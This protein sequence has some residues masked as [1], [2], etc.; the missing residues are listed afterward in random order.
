MGDDGV[1]YWGYEDSEGNEDFILDDD[2][3]RIPVTGT[4]PQ[5]RINPQTGNWEISTDGGIEWTDTGMPSQGTGD[6]LFEAVDQDEDYVYI[7]LRGGETIV[8]PKAKELL[9]DFGTDEEILY[10]TPGETKTL[11]YTMSGASDYSI[12]KPDGWRVMIEGSALIITAPAADNAFAES[13]GNINIILVA[14][15]GQ[16]LIAKLDVAVKAQ[17]EL[18]APQIGDFFYSDGTWSSEYDASKTALGIVFQTDPARIGSAETE[19]GFN[20]GLVMALKIA[21]EYIGW[22]DIK[23][24]IPELENT[25]LDAFYSDLSGLHNCTTV[26]NK[27]NYDASDYKA[28]G[29]VAAWNEEGSQYKAPA[30]TSGWFIPSSGQMYDMF[31]NL[32]GLGDMDEADNSGH[33]YFWEGNSYK[34]FAGKLNAWMDEIPDGQ[35]DLF[36]ADGSS[37]HLWTSSETYDSNARAWAIYAVG[38]VECESCQKTWGADMSVRAI[39][40]F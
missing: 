7:T 38:T 22:S 17:Q 20:H 32:A 24:D 10:F 35:K 30:N 5:V 26:W 4:A 23:E 33:N 3:N 34:D 36:M 2:G 13:E 12:A 1:Y 15:N 37:D 31:R 18:P 40:A 28:F 8:L 27:D 25:Y 14:G 9:F 39:L 29:A 21:G 11:Q 19:A 6:S 16:S